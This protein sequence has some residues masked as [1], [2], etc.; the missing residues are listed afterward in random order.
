MN[1]WFTN[2]IDI[3]ILLIMWST[4]YIDFSIKFNYVFY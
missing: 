4:N 3:P 1:M 2:F